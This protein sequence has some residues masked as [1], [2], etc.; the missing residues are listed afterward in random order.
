MLLLAALPVLA[1]PAVTLGQASG[2]DAAVYWFRPERSPTTIASMRRLPLE[3][4]FGSQCEPVLVAEFA[5]GADGPRGAK[6]VRLGII[7][8]HFEGQ[9]LRVEADAAAY[10]LGTLGRRDFVEYSWCRSMP[11]TVGVELERTRFVAIARAH[12]IV[13]H[14]GDSALE[15]EPEH[16]QGLRALALELE[17][18]NKRPVL[19]RPP[20]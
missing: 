13:L 3:H 10:D 1:I 19:T 16:M 11:P 6:V 5:F 14:I 17:S 7:S 8:R 18:T 20:N 4:G 12:R 2:S 9:S 15:L